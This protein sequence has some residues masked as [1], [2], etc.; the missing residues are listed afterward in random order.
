MLLAANLVGQ[1]IVSAAEIGSPVARQSGEVSDELLDTLARDETRAE[2][3]SVREPTDVNGDGMTSPLDALILINEANGGF[4]QPRKP[5]F[6]IDGDRIVGAGDVLAV[7]NRCNLDVPPPP[8]TPIGSY[9]VWHNF[10][11]PY[12]LLGLDVPAGD[13]V[14]TLN[15]FLVNGTTAERPASYQIRINGDWPAVESVFEYEWL[16]GSGN[17]IEVTG[18]TVSVPVGRLSV[19]E[20]F[21][22]VVVTKPDAAIG[23]SFSLEVVSARTARGELIAL[24]REPFLAD[25]THP[26]R[27]EPFNIV[28]N[29]K[30]QV[31]VECSAMGLCTIDTD[32]PLPLGSFTYDFT[33]VATATA[34]V[35]VNGSLWVYGQAWQKV[36]GAGEWHDSTMQQDD[37]VIPAGRS[38]LEIRVPGATSVTPTWLM[39]SEVPPNTLGALT[40]YNLTVI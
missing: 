22:L 17:R 35:Y 4:S 23:D 14:L 5:E 29:P 10:D 24:R 16:G 38:V 40:G 27:T 33:G 6:D 34:S 21:S 9:D 30:A 2:G 15:W 20:M 31:D 26:W 39:F 12:G 37:L 19:P 25:Y 28:A 7:I 18:P 32:R 11:N 3:E 36:P 13:I 8:E 1:Q